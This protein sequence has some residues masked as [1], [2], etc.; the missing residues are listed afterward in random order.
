MNGNLRG[1]NWAFPRFTPSQ[2]GDP[3][4][5]RTHEAHLTIPPPFGIP[6]SRSRTQ[7]Q[8]GVA[9]TV[10]DS[11]RGSKELV[12]LDGSQGEGGGQMLRT[13]LTLSLLS[14]RPFQ[15]T[16][17]RANREKPGLRPQHCSAVRGGG[18]LG[19]RQ[20]LGRHRRI[21]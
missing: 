2:R 4:R 8:R 11:S 21:A 17:I 13:A 19:Q 12:I 10:A 1:D 14:G 15:M 18:T 6:W 20:N 5:W 7:E 16:R 9:R 3:K